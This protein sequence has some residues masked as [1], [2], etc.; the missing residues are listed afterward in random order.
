MLRWQR[1]LAAAAVM[2]AWS[3]W[4]AQAQIGHYN[5]FLAQQA[6][7]RPSVAASGTSTV[8]QKPTRLRMYVQLLA[9]GKNLEEALA[10]MKDRREAARTQL[11][12]LKADKKSIVFGGPAP[13]AVQSAQKRQ[14]EALIM[15]QMQARG[16]KV[17]AG[18]Q[19][20]Q[21]VSLAETLTAE[22]P[23]EAETHEQLLL[24]AHAIQERIKAADLAGSKEAEKL[25]PEEE[26]LAEEAAKM[27]AQSYGEEA[28]TPGQAYFMYVAV[29]SK[30]NREKAQAEAF[31]K[32]KTQ[33][34]AL[35]KAAGIELGPLVGL[36]GNC[37]GQ[38]SFAQAFG[39]YSSGNDS[40]HQLIA[41]QTGEDPEEKE[42]E[43]VS[44]DPGTLTFTCYVGATFAIGKQP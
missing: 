26:E 10:K 8:R 38:S 2:A 44:T 42:G 25:S 21:T 33:A 13:S 30:E 32:A 3:P 29:L 20:P 27:A 18:L 36:S 31:A 34:A 1:V 15:Q 5:D 28:P 23:L 19:V 39:R 11:E 6:A 9:K 24:A 16:K 22:W 4:A 14:M 17:P 41:Q 43:A 40:I 35:A 12:V 7:G 37:S